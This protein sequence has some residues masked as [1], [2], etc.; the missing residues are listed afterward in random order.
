MYQCKNTISDLPITSNI[1]L[2]KRSSNTTEMRGNFTLKTQFDDSYV[3]SIL[4][5]IFKLMKVFF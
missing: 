3:V 1:Y 4:K 2:S 5:T